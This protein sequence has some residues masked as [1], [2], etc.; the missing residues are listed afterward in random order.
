MTTEKEIEQLRERIIRLEAM[1][2][3]KLEE[4]EIKV[5][6]LEGEIKLLLTLISLDTTILLT[7]LTHLL[8]GL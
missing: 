2:G 3:K 6:K 7:L 8:G 1:D 4:L 5:A